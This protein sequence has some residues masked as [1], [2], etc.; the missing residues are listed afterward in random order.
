MSNQYPITACTALA[1]PCIGNPESP[2]LCLCLFLVVEPSSRVPEILC[3]ETVS[4]YGT[5]ITSD[6]SEM[7]K[8]LSDLHLVSLV[9]QSRGRNDIP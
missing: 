6:W 8:M 4:A 3:S 1:I 9:S 5:V 7:R 2:C